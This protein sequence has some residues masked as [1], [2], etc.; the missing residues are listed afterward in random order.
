MEKLTEFIFRLIF[1]LTGWLLNCS[2]QKN[3]D[4]VLK[5]SINKNS[6]LLSIKRKYIDLM[7]EN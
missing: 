1:N 5:L 6:K 3:G 7:V 4:L 2:S